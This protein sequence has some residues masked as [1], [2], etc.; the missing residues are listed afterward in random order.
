M[1]LGSPW[2]LLIEHSAAPPRQAHIFPTRCSLPSSSSQHPPCTGAM[3]AH[4]SCFISEFVLT[5][6]VYISLWCL[7]LLYAFVCFC[8][9]YVVCSHGSMHE[10]TLLILVPEVFLPLQTNSRISATSE[11]FWNW[12]WLKNWDLKKGSVGLH[13]SPFPQH[14]VLG[15]PSVWFVAI[16]RQCKRVQEVRFYCCLSEG[17]TQLTSWRA[18]MSIGKSSCQMQSGISKKKHQKNRQYYGPKLSSTK[19]LPSFTLDSSRVTRMPRM[20]RMPRMLWAL[21]DFLL[22]DEVA[23][24]VSFGTRNVHLAGHSTICTL[25]SKSRFGSKKSHYSQHSQW[26][27]ADSQ[28]CP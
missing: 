26:R 19:G 4:A 11:I 16:L 21:D 23:M 3:G 17:T 2:K 10:G 27:N 25:D 22:A 13:G 8:M 12:A 6:T 14:A 7:R 24:Q 18:W 20:P 9:M 5:C 28:S 15:L 1:L